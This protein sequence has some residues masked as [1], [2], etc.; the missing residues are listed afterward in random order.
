M[1]QTI[2]LIDGKEKL[3]TVYDTQLKPD[4]M[5][6]LIELNDIIQWVRN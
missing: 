5:Y 6:Y 4:G 3:I 2:M 1:K